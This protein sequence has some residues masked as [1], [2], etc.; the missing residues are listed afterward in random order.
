MGA[1]RRV[2]LRVQPPIPFGDVTMVPATLSGRPEA[3]LG[4][5]IAAAFADVE[6]PSAA[7]ILGRLRQS[8]PQ[9]P[10]SARMAALSVI[11]ERL[12]R[13]W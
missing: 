7:E 6:A 13:A 10:L 12:R 2:T 11:M 9:A 4:R 8:F 1:A 5:A 3:E